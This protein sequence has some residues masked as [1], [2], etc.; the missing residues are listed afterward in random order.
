[1]QRRIVPGVTIRWLFTGFGSRRINGARPA[2]SSRGPGLPRRRTAT[3]C[4]S[5]SS[6]VSFDVEPTSSTSPATSRVKIR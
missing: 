5:T 1:M 3:S 6:S 4:R 2:Q